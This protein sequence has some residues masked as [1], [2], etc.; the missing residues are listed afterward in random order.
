MKKINTK[1]TKKKNNKKQKALQNQ[2]YPMI[3]EYNVNEYVYT[4]AK[5]R[6]WEVGR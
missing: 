6:E 3:K 2:R 1:K 4:C 5:K